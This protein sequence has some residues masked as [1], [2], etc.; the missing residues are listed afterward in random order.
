MSS[1]LE[2]SLTFWKRFF[3]DKCIFQ[4]NLPS[5]TPHIFYTHNSNST[6]T[7]S[8]KSVDTS[9]FGGK[10]N[11]LES[12]LVKLKP[13]GGKDTTLKHPGGRE[14][15]TV[16]KSLFHVIVAHHRRHGYHI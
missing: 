15:L 10:Q 5:I 9:E 6:P 11:L 8:S 14:L 13:W 3:V 7:L 4:K 16:T 12:P 2:H 1:F